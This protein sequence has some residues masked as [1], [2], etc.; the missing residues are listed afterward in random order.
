MSLKKD[1]PEMFMASFQQTL[2]TIIDTDTERIKNQEFR[3]FFEQK[4]N[5]SCSK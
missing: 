3:F 4:K 5:V 2:K 1:N